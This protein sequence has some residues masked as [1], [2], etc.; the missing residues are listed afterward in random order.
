MRAGACLALALLAALGS[1]AAAA[2]P[3]PAE[4][5]PSKQAPAT[6]AGREPRLAAKAWALIDARDG[7]VLAGKAANRELPIASATKLMTAYVALEKLKP[8]KSVTAVPYRPIASAEILLGL[9][10]GERVRVRDLLYGLLLPSANDAA[11][12]LAVGV[13]GSEPAFVAEMNQAAQALGLTNTSFANPIGLDDPANYSTARD[14]VTLADELLADPLI[15]R[16]ADTPAATLRSGSRP[17]RVTTRNNLLLEHPFING[18]KTGHTLGAGYVLVS[19][20]TRDSTT[21]IAAV[22]GAPSEAARDAETLELLEY[23]FSRYRT[24]QPVSEGEELADPELDYR[25]ERL[26][27][28]A[29]DGLQVS[30]RRGQ[31]VEVAVDA[32]DE[33]SG[34]VEEGERLGE[35]IVTVDGAPA[36]RTAL[37]AARSAEAASVVDRTVATAQ[38]PVILLPAGMIVIV[39]GLLLAARGRRPEQETPPVPNRRRERQE[40]RQRTPEE[41]RRMHEERMRRRRERMKRGEGR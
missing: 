19:S 3:P 39:V 4:Q 29:R 6:D 8:S 26:P 16:I 7:T 20:G 32:P 23:G 18:V 27:L 14:L 11:H 10:A 24:T 22:L 17:R 41:R 34:A 28:L 30:A 21:L 1:G 9:R 37:V 13:A 31:A 15:A 5:A 38:N 2:Q 40:P 33:V 12:T 25:G 36:A 35:A